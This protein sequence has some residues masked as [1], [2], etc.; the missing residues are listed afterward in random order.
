MQRSFRRRHLLRLVQVSAELAVV[1]APMMPMRMHVLGKLLDTLCT[2]DDRGHDRLMQKPGNGDL[3]HSGTMPVRDGSENF[4]QRFAPPAIDRRR[5]QLLEPAACAVTAPGIFS[6]Q[7]ATGQGAPDQQANPLGGQQ[8]ENLT[9][10]VP[11]YQRVIRLQRDDGCKTPVG[12]PRPNQNLFT[13]WYRI[14]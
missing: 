1:S 4:N 9:L 2:E 7:I 14:V 13:D 6:R 8:W 12:V 10:Q 11:A 3:A 5:V